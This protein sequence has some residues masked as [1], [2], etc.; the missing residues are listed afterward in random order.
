MLTQHS[1]KPNQLVRWKQGLKN[2]TVPEYNEPAMVWEVLPQP[3][4]D[5]NR[6]HGAGSPYSSEPLDIVLAVLNEDK[7]LLLH[8]DSRRFEPMPQVNP[9]AGKAS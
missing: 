6:V 1:F 2:K 7:F 4:F 3:I 5:N 8:Y 9:P